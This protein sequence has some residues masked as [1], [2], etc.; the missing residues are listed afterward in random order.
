MSRL[1]PALACLNKRQRAF[2]DHYVRTGGKN[3]TESARQAGYADPGSHSSAIKVKGHELTHNHKILAALKYLAEGQAKASVIMA[4][5]TLV[6]LC[7]P[8]NP[9][10]VR[11]QAAN[12]VLA[13]G[14]MMI[15]KISE[16]NINHNDQ[17]MTATEIRAELR[18]LAKNDPV[19]AEAIAMRALD[20]AIDVEPEYPL[21]E[22]V[23]ADPD[24]EEGDWNV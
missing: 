15:T 24:A 23:N 17:K 22:D 18:R 14:G 4:M 9:P 11:R 19:L 2:V 20:T 7:Q 12:D 5:D 3:A 1:P 8:P 21:I 13:H 6:D 16:L 10:A